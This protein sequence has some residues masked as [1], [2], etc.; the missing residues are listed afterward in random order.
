[1]RPQ[2]Q[3][4]RKIEALLRRR[5]ERL[6]QARPRSPPS[7]Q[8]AAAPRRRPGSAAAATPSV[9]GKTVRRLS[10]RRPGRRARLP[11]PHVER[12]REPHRQRDRV[13][14][15]SRPFQP[16]QEP[17]PALRK[18]Q[19]DLGRAR[20]QAR[21][22]G[23]AACASSETLGQPRDGRRLE[24]AADRDLD[25]Q[26]GADAADQPR[27][28]QRMTAELEEVVVDADPLDAPAPRQTA[29][30]APPPAACAAAR[31]T[32]AA[33]SSG[34]GSARRS[35]LPFG[36]SGKPLQHHDRRRHHVVRQA[37]APACARSAAASSACIRAPP[38]HRP[39]AACR[40]AHP[41]ARSPPPA[42]P[43]AC[44]ISAASI[45]PGSIRNPRSFTCA[46]ARPRNS[47]TPSARQ[48]ARSPVRYI[49]L[50]ASTI[51]VGHEPLRRQPRATQIA[52]RQPRPRNVKLPRNP[53]RH[54]LQ[55]RR[56]ARKPACSRSDGRSDGAGRASPSSA[57]SWSRPDR[58]LGRAVQIDRADAVNAASAAQQVAR[59][60]RSPPTS[61]GASPASR[62]L[63]LD[64]AQ[65]AQRRHSCTMVDAVLARSDRVRVA[66]IAALSLRRQ[67]PEPR[68][69]QQ[70]TASLRDRRSRSRSRSNCSRRVICVDRERV[71]P[72]PAT[73]LV[74]AAMRDGD[75]LWRSG[76]ARGVDDVGGV[77]RVERERRARSMGCAAIAGQ[78]ASSRTIAA[79]RARAA[80]EQRRLGHQHR[81]AGILQHEGQ[82]LARVATD[83]AAD[84]RR[85]P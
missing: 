39:P 9:S 66:R 17:Q 11:A 68:P 43:P 48:R 50:P 3:L 19:R 74:N 52:A 80:V 37:R 33:S 76:G 49:R 40:R 29:R 60:R 85:R 57:K 67:Q 81:R 7:P 36:V 15:R 6:R 27:R 42:P 62:S 72:A 23:R 82:A 10:C 47:S 63:Q 84:R 5:R 35:S 4:A 21:S 78:S 51:R 46:S 12:A 1:M 20:Q 22:A 53:S 41:R 8:A 16:I 38:P 26:A 59:G 2:R 24:Q 14:A 44:R 77:V 32:A 54:R 45:S 18:R 75:A 71:D 79:R 13:G 61:P 65:P 69:L 28:Q 73:R 56:P 30:T 64:M 70:R 83:R 25:I 31:R 34:A 55:A 58:G